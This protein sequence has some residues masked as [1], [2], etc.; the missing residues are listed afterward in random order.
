MA[1]HERASDVL[2]IGGGVF[3]LWVARACLRRGMSVTLAE[4]GRIG[5]GASGGPVGALA[6]HA[7]DP[8][9]EAKAFQFAALTALPGEV[10]ALEAETGLPTGYARL[11]RAAPLRD[12]AAR[13]RA[14]ARAAEAAQ[15]WP[16]ARMWIEE[17]GDGW[18]AAPAGGVQRDDLTAKLTPRLYCAALKAAVA[19]AGGRIAEGLRMTGWNGAARF[20]AET[21]PA[22]ATVVAAGWE[23]FGLLATAGLDG[24]GEGEHGQ[25]ALLAAEAPPDAPLIQGSGLWIVPQP[26][27]VAV[28]S[29]SQRG[30]NDREIDAA[31]DDVV[32]RARALCP[33]LRDAP[34]V[35]RWAG[36]RP[37]A[38]TRAPLLGPVPGAPGLFAAT[39]GFKIGF[40]LA[41]AA[42]EAVAA[43][44]AGERPDL[45]PEFLA[46]HAAP[47]R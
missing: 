10:A 9:T 44:I 30:R 18:L 40:G 27:G 45:P 12:A 11:G 14:E 29:T 20:G 41:H 33:L 17:G 8:W 42:G 22:A 15:R 43:L 47:P 1:S 16:G 36:V 25:A 28:G 26:G 24:R 34:V 6:P 7:P 39:G 46:A 3:G 38:A 4:A 32:A 35:A 31:L 23:S 37:R 5:D 13:A 2:V 21:I 19:R